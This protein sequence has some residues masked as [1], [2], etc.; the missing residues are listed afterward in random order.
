MEDTNFP[1][2]IFH[3]NCFDHLQHIRKGF[4]KINPSKNVELSIIHPLQRRSHFLK[5]TTSCVKCVMFFNIFYTNGFTEIE[6][7]LPSNV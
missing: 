1:M 3:R 6:H 2:N 7:F 5:S 4:Q